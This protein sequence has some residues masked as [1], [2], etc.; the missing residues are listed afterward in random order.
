MD[1]LVDMI[2]L[3]ILSVVIIIFLAEIREIKRIK[4]YIMTDKQQSID[5]S[6]FDE[7]KVIHK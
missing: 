6:M 1:I 3:I 5:F 2:T 4:N 7:P